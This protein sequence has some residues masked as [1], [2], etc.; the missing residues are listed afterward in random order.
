MVKNLESLE[1]RVEFLINQGDLLQGEIKRRKIEMT[2][3]IDENFENI[4]AKI[5]RKRAEV[6]LK[7]Q[8]SLKLEETRIVKE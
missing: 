8:E 2:M 7:L 3:Q 1:R 6:K 4:M 5:L